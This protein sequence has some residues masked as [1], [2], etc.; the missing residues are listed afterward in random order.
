MC[1]G[2]SSSSSRTTDEPFWMC[3]AGWW[4]WPCQPPDG[5]MKAAAHLLGGTGPCGCQT[6]HWQH[7][8]HMLAG[9]AALSCT[10]SSSTQLHHCERLA[11]AH[12]HLQKL[13]ICLP[14]LS[15]ARPGMLGPAAGRKDCYVDCSSRQLAHLEPYANPDMYAMAEH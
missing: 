15:F 3:V 4:R 11:T 8:D 6:R 5:S 13:S 12:Y 14:K 1:Y 10:M 7:K 9:A 2:S